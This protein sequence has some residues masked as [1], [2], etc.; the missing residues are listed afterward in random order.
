MKKTRLRISGCGLFV[1]VFLFIV[2]VGPAYTKD[3]YPTKAIDIIVP[4]SPG[5]SQDLTTRIV[6][7]YVSKKWNVPVNVVHKPGGNSI[8]GSMVVQEAPPD[9]YAILNITSSGTTFPAVGIKNLPFNIYDRAYLGITN[10]FP[11]VMIVPTNSPFKS[12]KELIED[13]KKDPGAFTW[14]S[15][16][17]MFTQDMLARKLL[18]AINV[19]VNKTK[20]VLTQAG[21]TQVTLTAG[22]N[23]KLGIGS[24][25]T[26]IPAIQGGMVRGLAV[27]SKSRFPA[28]PDVPTLTELGYDSVS[29]DIWVGFSG[30]PK[31]PAPIVE[32]WEQAF[33]EM[34]KDPDVISKLKNIHSTPFYHTA[35]QMLTLIKKEHEEVASFFK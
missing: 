16:G 18:K 21:A 17:G 33:G 34:V 28:I 30:P 15:G 24:T 27:T 9:G 5:G 10:V 12:L 14:T 13:I 20:P 2:G 29:F 7:A 11:Q 25:G 1:L 6:A 22:G 31:L 4:T 19:D 32:K 8:P 23:V 3:D 26:T 35:S